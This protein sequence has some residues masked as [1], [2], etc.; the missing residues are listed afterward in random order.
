MR[1]TAVPGADN[2]LPV[3]LDGPTR[4]RIAILTA[5][6]VE[7]V[8]FFYPYYRFVEAGWTV[9]VITPSGGKLTGYRGTEL[10][11]TRPLSDATPDSYVLLF[12]PGGLAPA[13]LVENEAAIDFVRRYAQSN[14]LIGSVCHGPRLLVAAGLARGQQL[15]AFWHVEDEISGAGGT[16]LDVPVVDGERIIT[17][18]KPGDMPREMAR[19]MARLDKIASTEP[20][21]A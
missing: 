16:Y 10:L 11:D 7:D 5:D 6:K 4:G 8:E 18:R 14:G 3:P 20:Q 17:A 2:R 13:T 19:I 9:D 21:A 1:S 15:T 12:I